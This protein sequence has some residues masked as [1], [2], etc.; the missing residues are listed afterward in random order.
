LLFTVAAA[1]AAAANMLSLTLT[2]TLARHL[3]QLEYLSSVLEWKT[4]IC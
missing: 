4:L 3:L 2:G 1:A